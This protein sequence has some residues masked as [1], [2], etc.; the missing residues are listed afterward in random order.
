MARRKKNEVLDSLQVIEI[1]ED[2]Q[3]VVEFKEKYDKFLENTKNTWTLS[4]KAKLSLSAS[5]S[6]LSTKHGF[7]SKIPLI[8]KS[9]KCPFKTTC[10]LYKHSLEPAGE[11]CPTEIAMILTLHEKY[12]NELQIEDNDTV[13]Q[14]LLRDLISYEVM[15]ARC[16]ARI[17]EEG[18]YI[19]M[20]DVGVTENGDVVS[21]PELSQ[22]IIYKEK[23]Q[24]KKNEILQ[25]LN[26]T[27][28]DKSSSEVNMKITPVQIISDI[29]EKID[30]F[31]SINIDGE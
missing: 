13:D 27:R 10:Q 31:D 24:K 20:I 11:P 2:D 18:D 5:M 14:T 30:E 12:I 8:C 15:L 22:S 23:I 29:V 16:D 28:K 17:A 25:L 7:Y 3:E 9:D 4:E 19:Q 21:K 1:N 26:S 6:M